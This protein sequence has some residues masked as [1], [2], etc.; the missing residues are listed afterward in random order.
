MILSNA[1]LSVGGMEKQALLLAHELLEQGVGIAFLSKKQP[2]KWGEGHE[3]GEAQQYIGKI[4]VTQLPILALQPGWSFLCS[5]M[6]W[7]V[8]HRKS[9]NIIHAH[10]PALGVIACLIA[11]ILR[12]KVVV[13]VPSQKNVSYLNGSSLPRKLRRWVLMQK[14]SRFVAVSKE[15][16]QSLKAVG[17]QHER[18]SLIPNGIKLEPRGDNNNGYDHHSLKMEL[19]GN[20][21]IQVVLFIGRLV[22]EKGLDRL[23]RVWSLMPCY[24]GKMLCIVGDGPLR[25]DLEDM[26]GK[27]G[28]LPSVRFFGHQ[29][30]VTKFYAI[31]DLFVLSSKTEG[32]SNALLEAMAAGIPP[33]VS[34]VGGNRDV[35]MD[36]N[37]GFLLDWQDTAGCVKALMTF[38]TDPLLRQHIGIAARDR[39]SCFALELIAER[40]QQLYRAVLWKAEDK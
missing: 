19:L 16:A 1:S 40:Y 5:F 34:N 32:M 33:L 24:E 17:I 39:A 35:I 30:N 9:F 36:K 25:K 38:L 13:K 2:A 20:A 8:I 29:P 15:I 3:N 14:A 27:L 4:K 21:E 26:A 37:N 12:K 6:I 31:A 10:N 11:W 23:L 22:E 28:I 7:A 18:I